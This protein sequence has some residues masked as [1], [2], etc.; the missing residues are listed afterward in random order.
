MKKLLKK[1]EIKISF[2]T[3]I[4]IITAIFFISKSYKSEKNPVPTPGPVPQFRVQKGVVFSNGLYLVNQER[5]KAGVQ[6]VGETNNIDQGAYNRAKFLVEHNQWSHKGFREAMRPILINKQ[7]EL[8]GEDLAKNFS[9]DEA[10][11]QAWMLSPIHK[12]V[13]LNP[14]YEWGGYNCYK[15]ICV[16]WLAT[17][18]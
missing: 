15:K 16:L 13:M 4:V 8:I 3:A 17:E 1:D 5:I 9:T 18:Y 2:I 6:L 12:D 7:A 14:N 11:I 10:V